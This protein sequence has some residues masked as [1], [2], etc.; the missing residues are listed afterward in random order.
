M[1]A[2]D[3]CAALVDVEGLAASPVRTARDDVKGDQQ[4]MKFIISVTRISLC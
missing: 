1:I 2:Q 4:G 3:S